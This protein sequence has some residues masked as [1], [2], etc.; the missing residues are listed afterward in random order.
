MITRTLLVVSLVASAAMAQAASFRAP[1]TAGEMVSMHLKSLNAQTPKNLAWGLSKLSQAAAPLVQGQPMNGDEFLHQAAALKLMDWIIGSKY[2]DLN[3]PKVKEAL[4]ADTVAGINAAREAYAKSGLEF[5]A[6]NAA[7]NENSPERIDAALRAFYDHALISK[8]REYEVAMSI[9]ALLPARSGLGKLIAPLRKLKHEETRV[10]SVAFIEARGYGL[11]ILTSSEHDGQ[12]LKLF[13]PKSGGPG[14]TLPAELQKGSGSSYATEIEAVAP[15]SSFFVTLGGP[16]HPIVYHDPIRLGK[17]QKLWPVSSLAPGR[18]NSRENYTLRA[19]PFKDSKRLLT[20][21]NTGIINLWKKNEAGEFESKASLLPMIK[22]GGRRNSLVNV[23]TAEMSADN[24]TLVLGTSYGL[25]AKYKIP[26][27]PKGDS[28]IDAQAWH[29]EDYAAVTALAFHGDS[30]A[31]AFSMKAH[32]ADDYDGGD[33]RFTKAS[34]LVLDK[35]LKTQRRLE[36]HVEDGAV[37][38]LYAAA[39]RLVSISHEPEGAMRLWSLRNG[40]QVAKIQ[41]PSNSLN[42]DPKKPPLDPIL[43]S[44]L[45]P[46]KKYVVLGSQD[47]NLLVVDTKT[48]KVINS[49]RV[50]SE[51]LSLAFDRTGKYLVT[52]SH[53]GDSRLFRFTQLL[54]RASR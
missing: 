4:G 1:A 52:G 15:D 30:I 5:A 26:Q 14:S 51:V 37:G 40:R 48:G 2:S 28:E 31:A 32:S 8:P 13:D 10:L 27:N 50:G 53:L 41:I 29:R 6:M 11:R 33:D 7:S 35:N 44:A 43:A 12:D 19:L 54:N 42:I 38:K 18:S 22:S 16:N 47:G 23:R 9:S 39:G 46:D 24:K 20:V 49:A 34:I 45:S 36:G 3:S 25:I 17:P 21:S